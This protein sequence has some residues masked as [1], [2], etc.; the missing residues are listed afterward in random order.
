MNTVNGENLVGMFMLGC[1]GNFFLLTNNSV[2]LV[3]IT[4]YDV[5]SHSVCMFIA[6]IINTNIILFNHIHGP[7]TGV[8]VHTKLCR[9][10]FQYATERSS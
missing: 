9:H 2:I 3:Q 8:V 10:S 7:Y 6:E 1:V 5:L 4:C